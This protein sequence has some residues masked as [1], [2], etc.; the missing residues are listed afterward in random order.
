MLFVWAYR[1]SSL[2]IFTYCE[3]LR[4]ALSWA[5]R[6]PLIRQGRSS[7]RARLGNWTGFVILCVKRIL[8]LRE[9]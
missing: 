1:G 9:S 6:L 8:G 5:K 2:R 3:P 7:K 4:E